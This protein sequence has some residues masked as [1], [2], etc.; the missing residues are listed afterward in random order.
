MESRLSR[1]LKES[2]SMIICRR[3]RSSLPGHRCPSWGRALILLA[4]FQLGIWAQIPTDDPVEAQL[5]WYERQFE[6]PDLIPGAFEVVRFPTGYKYEPKYEH[7]RKS[8][9]RILNPDFYCT[10]CVREKRIDGQNRRSYRLMEQEEEEVM[11]FLH[12]VS[13]RRPIFLEDRQFRMF[14]GLDGIN[15]KKHRNP[16]LKEELVELADIFPR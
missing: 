9:K 11:D 14:I 3:L 5:K 7:D 1:G 2:Q 13:K 8:K 16:F 12:T 6:R 15:A 4:M 10:Q